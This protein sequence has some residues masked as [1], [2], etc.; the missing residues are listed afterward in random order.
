[1]IERPKHPRS[2]ELQQKIVQA[3]REQNLSSSDIG[4]MLAIS[5]ELA[6]HHVKCL[7]KSG[8]VELHERTMRGRQETFLWRLSETPQM[9]RFAWPANLQL[10][11][12]KPVP[13][14]MLTRWVGGNPY[15]RLA[16]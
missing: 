3:L 11:A 13:P 12:A 9:D 5:S 6:R 8:L 2:V 14:S 1:M 7:V 4:R 10:H 15:E 16:A